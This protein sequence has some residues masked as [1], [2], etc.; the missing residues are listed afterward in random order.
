[1]RKI[2]P[3]LCLFLVCAAMTM[4]AQTPTATL[5][6]IVKDS[7]GAVIQGA[8]VIVTNRAQGST[9]ETL[10]N[11]SGSYAIPELLPGEYRDRKSVV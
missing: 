10:T 5:S 3:I 4:Q 8:R 7:Q 6:G 2:A 1:M 9:R 11:S